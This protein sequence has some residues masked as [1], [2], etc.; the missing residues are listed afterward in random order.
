MVVR[1]LELF[2]CL[3]IKT[4]ALDACANLR[5]SVDIV[6]YLAQF[7]IHGLLSPAVAVQDD[8]DLLLSH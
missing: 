4:F 8:S 5:F 2:A 6:D 7:V 3:I 1:K